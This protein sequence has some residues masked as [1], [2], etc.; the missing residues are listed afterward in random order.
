VALRV[1]TL[2]DQI[3]DPAETILLVLLASAGIVFII[4]CANVANLILA[5]TVRREGELIVR[6]A[7]G[8][9]RGA[10]R[11][12]LLAESLLLCGAGA[13]L[14][15]ALARPLVAIVAGYAARFSVRALDVTVDASLLWVGAGLA[16][17][18]AVFLAYI[19][20]LPSALA[21]GHR[22]S[23]GGARITPGANR[24]LRVFA[25]TQVALS[26]VLLAGAA[27]LLAALVA[28]QTDRS[29]YN[30]RQ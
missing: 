21:S 13:V 22:P 17:A 15:V 9:S 26:F 16:I 24:R 7:L 11:R 8:A 25:T 3:V 4:A 10:L 28:L 12:A 5:R 30:L 14:G 27:M 20:R 19:P 2:R 1:T 6:D 18:A 29:G 23:S